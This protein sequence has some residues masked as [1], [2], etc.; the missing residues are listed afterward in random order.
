[1]KRLLIFSVI[2]VLSGL[3]SPSVLALN[4]TTKT[5]LEMLYEQKRAATEK[6][7]IEMLIPIAGDE[8][9]MRSKKVK[10]MNFI[11]HLAGGRLSK[12]EKRRVRDSA[13]EAVDR[14]RAEVFLS[15]HPELEEKR[16]EAIR[17]GR[18]EKGMSKEEVVA[19]LGDPEK[20]RRV[21]RRSEF[22]E[23]WDYFTQRRFVYFREGQLRFW[24]DSDS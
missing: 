19:S 11:L 6:E 9:L 24:G 22:D 13:F 23:R 3:Y 8:G 15:R 21:L 1:M 16:R 5:I 2:C 20:I 7:L 12:K 14:I 4:E 18:L 10:E 17:T